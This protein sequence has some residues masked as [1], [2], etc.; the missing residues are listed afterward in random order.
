MSFELHVKNGVEYYGSSIIEGT[1]A[2][3]HFF[4]TRRGGISKGA[5]NSLN[6]GLYT[7]DDEDNI[8]ENYRRI[9]V[10]SNMNVKNITYLHQVHGDKFYLVEYVNYRQI[11]GC[12]GDAIITSE[13][14][15][16]IGVMTADCIPVILLD[17][18]KGWAAAVHAGWKGT[19]LGIASKVVDY[20]KVELGCNEGDIIAAVGPGIGPCCFEVGDEVASK[21]S[22][23][24]EKN[25]RKYVDL[26][27]ENETQLRNSGISCE[28]MDISQVCTQ[29][30]NDK[31]F[32]FRGEK[33]NTGRMG[34]FIELVLEG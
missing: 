5:Y 19:S 4:S 30:N 11:S 28:N 12:D 7:S 21:F 27:R 33:G 1:G 32:S 10:E 18:K 20:M 29:C 8:I 6:L 2:A 9:M 26:W 15:I 14:G 22:F 17:P 3:R 16:P 13:K 23:V 24:S 31:L 25:G 34:A